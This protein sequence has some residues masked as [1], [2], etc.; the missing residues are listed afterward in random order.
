M[1]ET[2]LNGAAIAVFLMTL[3]ALLGPLIHLSPAVPALAVFGFLGLATADQWVAEG[4]GLTLL[5]ALLASPE[6][7]RR[8]LCH[9]AGHFLLA[10]CLD[11]PVVGYQLSPWA[12][13]RAGGQGQAGVQFDPDAWEEA[14]KQAPTLPQQMERWATVWMGGIAAEQIRY[15]ADEGGASDRAQLR[16]GFGQLGLPPQVWPQKENWALLQAK[17][18]LRERA[19]ALEQ[20][21]AA[22]AKG[23]SVAECYAL[24]G[25]LIQKT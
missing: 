2:L 9:E 11:I 13:W 6:Q 16:Q 20:L 8:R 23:K 19:N 24:L 14:L 1:S 21:E 22:L 7:K 12:V 25:E 10:Y 4:R 15:G 5:T 17:N 18:L 3:S